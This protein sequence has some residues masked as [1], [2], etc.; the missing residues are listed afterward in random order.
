MKKV[1]IYTVFFLIL[2]L[3][4][5][6]GKSSEKE[7]EVYEPKEV[8][9][10]IEIKQIATI[11]AEEGKSKE[12]IHN[13]GGSFLEIFEIKDNKVSGE[14]WSI[15]RNSFKIAYVSFEGILWENK[16]SVEFEDDGFG[17]EGVIEIV[18]EEDEIAV[19]ITYSK[20]SIED[21]ALQS[22]ILTIGEAKEDDLE[23]RI[24][25]YFIEINDYKEKHG[26]TDVDYDSYIFDTESRVFGIEEIESLTI[27]QRD[28]F[29]NEI[30]ARHGYI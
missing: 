17:N 26:C 28:I 16:I 9:Q 8:Q 15:Q 19:A 3:I 29:R 13:E 4:G 10:D 5:C 11:W 14:Y 24:N 7:I 1:G 22:S 2:I 21:W 20:I 30:Y 23:E 6:G 27:I 12:Q 25:L 18:L